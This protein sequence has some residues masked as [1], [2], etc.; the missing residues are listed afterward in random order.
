MLIGAGSTFSEYVKNF[1]LM[2][3]ST[4]SNSKLRIVD[5]EIVSKFDLDSFFPYEYIS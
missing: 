5:D 2:G 4:A 3:I 1:A